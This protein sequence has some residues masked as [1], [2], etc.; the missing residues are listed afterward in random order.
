M[1]RKS[2]HQMR[3]GW[4]VCTLEDLRQLQY[5]KNLSLEHVIEI[6]LIIL[7]TIASTCCTQVRSA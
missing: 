5:K 2:S 6:F 3:G 1:I 7:R 4:Y